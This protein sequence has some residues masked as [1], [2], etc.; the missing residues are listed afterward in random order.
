MRKSFLNLFIAAYLILGSAWCSVAAADVGRSGSWF[1]P[2]HNGEGFIVQFIDDSRAVIYWFTYDEAGAQ[3]W[4]TGMGEANGNELYIAELLITDGGVHGPAFDP[5]QIVRTPIGELTLTFNSDSAALAEYMINGVAGQQNLQ[6]L[7]R[8]VEAGPAGAVSVPHKSG[9]WFDPTHNGEGFVVEVLP[10]G[11]LLAYWFTYD[12]SGRQAWMMALSERSVAQGSTQLD[13]LQPVGGRFGPDFDPDDVTREP[14]GTARVGLACNGGF[15]DF[16]STDPADFVD[17]RFGL[18]RIVGIGQV[19]CN[20]PALT[21]LYPLVDGEVAIPDHAAGRHLR[22]LLD[23]TAGASAFTDAMIMEHFSDQWL[24]QNSIEAARALLED[25]RSTYPGA[26]LTDPVA[27]TSTSMTGIFTATTGLDAFFVL[28]SNLAE[29]K[30]TGLNVYNYGYGTA[31]VVSA[32]DAML[33]L[34]QAAD[35]FTSLSAQPSLLL[36]RINA[37]N[38]CEPLV[39]RNADVLRSIASVFKIWILAGVVD[40]LEDES[41]FHDQVVLLDGAKQVNG[42]PLNAEPAGMEMTID[43][44]STLMLGVSDNTA[45]DMLLGLAGRGRI[46]GLHAE[47]GHQTPEILAPQL[48]ISEQFHLFFSFPESEALDYVTGTEAFQQDFLT[49]RIVPLGSRATGGG[50]YNNESLFIDGAWQASPM[51]ICGAFARHRLHPPGSDAALL[52]ERALQAGVAQPNVRENWDRVWYK[53]GSLTSGANGTLVLTHAF[54][55]EKEGEQPIVLVGL[56]NNPG[57]DIDP[58][59]IQSILGRFLELAAEL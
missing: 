13:L 8:P 31:S 33:D 52:V 28:N 40:A 41:L 38:Q 26:R 56:S 11:R 32:S 18:Q 46:D 19:A 39:T 51:D 2:T 7:T 53:G 34:E 58:F 36:A 55:L 37:A 27:M 54:M 45:T 15:Q 59:A 20:D 57:S 48:G 50:G 30:I 14:V 6:R 25:I 44:L 9:S 43:E 4:F 16:T 47:Y 29:G 12:L 1:D 42:G 5:N 21:N 10:D 35:R 3:R 22:W 17:I 24:A 23:Q 49:N